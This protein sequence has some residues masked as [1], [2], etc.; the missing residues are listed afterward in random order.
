[1]KKIEPVA[2]FFKTWPLQDIVMYSMY[3]YTCE[4][5]DIRDMPIAV[6]LLCCSLSKQVSNFFHTTSLLLHIILK[7]TEACDVFFYHFIPSSHQPVQEMSRN[8]RFSTKRL[9]A[10][11]H[12]FWFIVFFVVHDTGRDR[13]NTLFLLGCCRLE[14]TGSR[15]EAGLQVECCGLVWFFK[16]QSQYS[17]GITQC[18]QRDSNLC[19]AHQRL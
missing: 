15:V 12:S 7:E 9:V 6:P 1:M 3:K 13:R 17:R 10:S 19:P 2:H 18:P 4:Y 14:G 8:V 11:C 16:G 5:C